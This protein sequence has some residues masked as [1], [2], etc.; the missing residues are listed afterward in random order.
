MYVCVYVRV[1]VC[2][3]VCMYVCVCV[4]MYNYIICVC[5]Y[6]CVCVCMHW[7]PHVV[8]QR[9]LRSFAHAHVLAKVMLRMTYGLMGKDLC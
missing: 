2:T 9:A 1:C 7:V 3:C 6:V 5:V 8:N 4:C